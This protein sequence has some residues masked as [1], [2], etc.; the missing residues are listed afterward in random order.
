MQHTDYSEF[1]S[2]LMILSH[3]SI[4]NVFPAEILSIVS[5]VI[6][7]LV[8]CINMPIQMFLGKERIFFCFPY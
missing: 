3:V 8:V 4:H 5:A 6:P 7:V 2:H 1:L